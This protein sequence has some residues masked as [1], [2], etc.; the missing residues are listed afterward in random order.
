MSSSLSSFPLPPEIT[1]F[2]LRYA[3][4]IA[5]ALSTDV[6]S[7]YD[8][9]LRKFIRQSPQASEARRTRTSLLRVCKAWHAIGRELIFEHLTVSSLSDMEGMVEKLQYTSTIDRGRARRLD[10]DTLRGNTIDCSDVMSAFLRILSLLPNLEILNIELSFLT[11]DTKDE[12][13]PTL[14]GRYLPHLKSLRCYHQ[15]SI[16]DHTARY[17]VNND[18]QIF[19]GFWLGQSQ[20]AWPPVKSNS[21]T[22]IMLLFANHGD[23]PLQGLNFPALRNFG[24]RGLNGSHSGLLGFLD[25]HGPQI[26]S[27]ALSYDY[28]YGQLENEIL[29]RCR[30]LQEFIRGPAPHR[31][32]SSSDTYTTITRFGMTNCP[33]Y[34]KPGYINTT[35][36][37]ERFPN[38]TT[39]RLLDV[40]YGSP[41]EGYTNQT[42]ADLFTPR[43]S[44]IFEDVYGMHIPEPGA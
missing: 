31:S 28:Y 37:L 44:I 33:S 19:E 6:E 4:D 20:F 16:F 38:L 7:F 22:T 32:T 10:V 26:T 21:I 11:E 18:L 29:D 15:G 23:L 3:G 42:V 35:Y 12:S 5:G 41:P 34:P 14:I 24:A 8:N 9:H 27:M 40:Q 30:S 2:I 25:A 13:L 39:I 17:L 1:F 36:Q 43:G